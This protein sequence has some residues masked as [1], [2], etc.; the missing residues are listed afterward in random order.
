MAVS[1]AA[2]SHDRRHF[3]HVAICI[4]NAAAAAG[5]DDENF[6]GAIVAK[7]MGD[8]VGS[9]G[10]WRRLQAVMLCISSRIGEDRAAID[11]LTS[12]ACSAVRQGRPPG[13]D[14]DVRFPRVCT[15]TF[16]QRS[17]LL[18]VLSPLILQLGLVK[19]LES[20]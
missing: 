19:Q 15:V 11:V 4:S 9:K 17:V 6:F 2:R 10:G 20:G 7:D 12:S 16:R 14:C 13:P 18:C 8:G 3:S 1:L 5:D